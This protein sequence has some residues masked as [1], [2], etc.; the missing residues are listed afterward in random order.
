MRGSQGTAQSEQSDTHGPPIVLITCL[1]GHGG[2]LTEILEKGRREGCLLAA[3]ASSYFISVCLYII[4]P[5]QWLPRK[6]IEGENISGFRKRP[7]RWMEDKAITLLCLSPLLPASS[8]SH[9]HKHISFL[10]YAWTWW[11]GTLGCCLL[12][13]DHL[14]GLAL[15]Q[16]QGCL[17]S[18]AL[19]IC[20][21]SAHQ[22]CADVL[23]ISMLL[24]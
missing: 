2:L 15:P 1:C 11:E 21:L 8:T 19:S 9:L 3:S 20:F 7:G 10:A 16:P 6:V 24:W 13:W 23:P 14:L 12:L 4:I 22:F 18:V 5:S 17:P